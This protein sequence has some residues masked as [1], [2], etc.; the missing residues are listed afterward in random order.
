MVLFGKA[1]GKVAP[2]YTK[3]VID[4]LA[5]SK[6]YGQTG[7]IPNVKNVS[8][9]AQKYGSWSLPGTARTLQKFGE[10]TLAYGI[11]E[12]ITRDDST[13]KTLTDAT[14]ESI[15]L[16]P[17][18]GS[19]KVNSE[20]MQAL[21][22][23]SM[24]ETKK[25]TGKKKAAAILR[26]R[27]KFAKE[28]TAL[29]GGLNIALRGLAIPT[30]KFAGRK[31]ASPILSKVGDVITFAEPVV[32]GTL[33]GKYSPLPFVAKKLSKVK[34]KLGFDVLT[35]AGIPPA[36]DWKLLSDVGGFTLPKVRDRWLKIIDRSVLTP[37]RTDRALPG[38]LAIIKQG[39]KEYIKS[40]QK[41][42][43]MSL[44]NIERKI[45]KL[46]EVGMGSR[47]IGRGGT[48]KVEQYW[49]TVV[50]ALNGDKLVFKNLDKSLSPFVKEIRTQI[51]DLSKC[52]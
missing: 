43:D 52:T 28:G 25:L 31:I 14:G 41:L 44:R 11:G 7:T 8:N 23:T 2:G 33:T 20:A 5:K 27:L 51:D 37:L 45:Y 15:N 19:T 16:S 12:Y 40:Q 30:I 6:T 48:L 1:A 35:K 50:E 22:N 10:G 46:A 3:R 47:V 36:K 32:A 34:T 38:E 49:K 24:E 13:D 17:F 29:I 26:N 21:L 39:E 18:A 42:V 4:A 9:I